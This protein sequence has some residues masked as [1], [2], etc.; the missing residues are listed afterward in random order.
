MLSDNVWNWLEPATVAF[1]NVSRSEVEN[2]IASG[3]F[4]L[5]ITEH[6]A[7]VTCAFGRSLRIGLAGGDLDELLD[8]EKDICDYALSHDF[9]SIEII[10]RPGWERVLQG[11]RRTAVLMRKELD[12][13]GIH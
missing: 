10:G 9:D 11:Y 1:E 7:A 5:F 3:D 6:S 13:H 4:Q 2:G 8:M 12:S